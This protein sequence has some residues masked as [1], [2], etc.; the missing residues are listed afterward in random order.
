MKTQTCR[1]CGN[2]F[3]PRYLELCMPQK[4][5]LCKECIEQ[6]F[7]DYLESLQTRPEEIGHI[8]NKDCWCEPTLE[9][10]NPETDSQVWVHREI[11]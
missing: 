11:H 4:I 1:G 9:Y 7:L 3:D 2:S 6:G 8:D 5:L 10:K